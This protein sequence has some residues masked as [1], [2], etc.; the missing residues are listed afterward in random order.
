VFAS[1]CV[2]FPAKPD[3]ADSR[4]IGTNPTLFGRPDELGP[5]FGFGSNKVSEFAGRLRYWFAAKG[6]IRD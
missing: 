6:L 2:G 5:L 1:R 4:A 3:L